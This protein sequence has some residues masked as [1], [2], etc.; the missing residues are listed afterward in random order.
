M[1]SPEWE[2]VPFTLSE[3]ER[4]NT[5]KVL[6]AFAA[7]VPS[8]GWS[9][10]DFCSWSGVRCLGDNVSV[11]LAHSGASGTLPEMP[12]DVDYSTVRLN[13]ISI[14][15][16]RGG[17]TGTLP[18]S[19]GKLR[20]VRTINLAYTGITGTLSAS[21]SVMEALEEITLLNTRITGTLPEAWSD[22][23]NVR[24]INL[25]RCNLYGSLPESWARMPSLQRVDLHENHFC[26]CVPETW[27]TSPRLLV[28]VDSRHHI[29]NCSTAQACAQPARRVPVVS[30]L[31]TTTTAAPAMPLQM[32]TTALP[33]TTSPPQ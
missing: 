31:G 6:Q 32:N 26:G 29:A 8:L 5:L 10:D 13:E 33:S 3:A 12:D 18:S 28:G 21:W 2:A 14:F 15:G 9:G 11:L 27:I 20:K 22:M 4:L 17:I 1:K 25:Q 7:A 30:T 19:W 16:Q 24:R 23:R